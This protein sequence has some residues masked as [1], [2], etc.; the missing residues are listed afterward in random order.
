MEVSA[1][2]P[3]PF[4]EDETRAID[5][6]PQVASEECAGGIGNII[7]ELDQMTS[8]A[9]ARD[10]FDLDAASVKFIDTIKSL[11]NACCEDVPRKLPWCSI[12]LGD[13]I[14][15]V[16]AS[17]KCV[18]IV[19]AAAK[20]M[21]GNVDFQHHVLGVICYTFQLTK[22]RSQY[23]LETIGKHWLSYN[24]SEV[25][26]DLQEAS[27]PVQTRKLAWDI[28]YILVNCVLK[29]QHP[30]MG[31]ELDTSSPKQLL[32]ELSA[33]HMMLKL[34]NSFAV[35]FP[36]HLPFMPVKY[37]E[38]VKWPLERKEM[39]HGKLSSL[40]SYSYDATQDDL[41]VSSLLKSSRDG[42]QHSDTTNSS[43]SG[44][45]N[46]VPAES[47][48]EKV[49]GSNVC[50]WEPSKKRQPWIGKFSFLAMFKLYQRLVALECQ[51]PAAYRETAI[52]IELMRRTFLTIYTEDPRLMTR[53]KSAVFVTDKSAASCECCKKKYS[54][55]MSMLSSNRKHTCR[56]CGASTCGSCSYEKY[57][58]DEI[59]CK[60]CH[61]AIDNIGFLRQNLPVET[62]NEVSI[63]V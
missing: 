15:P 17:E 51:S 1:P 18:A 57:W 41:A 32:S 49:Q 39:C 16:I 26:S 9:A 46:D 5:E 6:C 61:A 60:T 52:V 38:E 14:H 48:E 3:V 62:W 37:F 53:N 42:S 28:A 59:C 35:T 45:S 36:A 7:S 29:P 43:H 58:N 20:L 21:R 8:V 12:P 33:I 40:F 30:S 50:L 10:E 55:M 31:F 47:K 11:L 24:V 23:N 27:C 13:C 54:L 19:M 25:L 56:L 22:V 4:A 2:L 44:H 34:F 63:S